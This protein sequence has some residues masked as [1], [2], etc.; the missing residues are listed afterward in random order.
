[1]P[2]DAAG[3]AAKLTNVLPDLAPYPLPTDVRDGLLTLATQSEVLI[4]GEM[5]GTREVPRL[6][7]ELLPTLAPLG[8]RGLALEIPADAR[9]T[10]A[11]WAV[12]E[13]LPVPGFFAAPSF[14]GRGNAEA[15]ALIRTALRQSVEAWQLLCF[16]EAS[17]DQSGGWAERDARMAQNL[18]AQRTLLC[19]NGKVIAVCGNMHSRVVRRSQPEDWSHALWPSFAAALGEQNPQWAVRSVSIVFRAGTFYNVAVR[20]MGDA[21]RAPVPAPVRVARPESEHTLELHLPRS[22]AASF[23][24]S[25]SN[26]PEAQGEK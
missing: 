14:D 18:A 4:V 20:T 15:L 26:V 24:A 11:D 7:A 9:D 2:D 17:G 25:P 5:H 23:L 1:M 8:Y 21:S 3:P 13:D 6:I 19:P 16:D 10:L 12:S 22:T